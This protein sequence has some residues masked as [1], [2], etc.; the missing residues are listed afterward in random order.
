[1][2]NSVERFTQCFGSMMRSTARVKSQVSTYK[3]VDLTGLRLLAHLQNNGPSRMSD[4]AEELCVDPAIITR[5]SYALLEGGFVERKIN[6]NDA[7][8]TLLVIT[9]AG[10]TLSKNHSEVRNAFFSEVFADWSQEE[11]IQFTNSIERFTTAL[12]EKTAGPTSELKIKQE[13]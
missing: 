10:V 9:A 2:S 6:P 1:M 7:R 8:G 11:I 13:K 5:Q 12:N 3:G 4:L